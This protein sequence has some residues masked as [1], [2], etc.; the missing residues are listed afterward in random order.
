MFMQKQ[1]SGTFMADEAGHL[2]KMGWGISDLL[3]LLTSKHVT[4]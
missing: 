3:Q 1:N 4:E 2:L